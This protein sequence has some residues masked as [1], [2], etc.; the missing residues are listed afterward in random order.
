MIIFSK[1]G[2]FDNVFQIYARDKQEKENAEYATVINNLKTKH[3]KCEDNI[4]ILKEKRSQIQSQ[5]SAL[6]AQLDFYK[7]RLESIKYFIFL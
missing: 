2:V 4:L 1:C 6:E 7:K 5:Q 3:S